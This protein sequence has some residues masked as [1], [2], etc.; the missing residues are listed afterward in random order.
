LAEI[1][2]VNEDNAT[3]TDDATPDPRDI[4]AARETLRGLISGYTA[5]QVLH[6]AAKLRLADHLAEGAL[7]AAALAGRAGADADVVQRLLNGLAAMGVV[8][9]EPGGS[10]RLTAVGEGMREDVPGSMATFALLSGE[11]YYQAWLGLDPTLPARDARTPFQRVFG[12]PV[13]DWFARHPESGER[14]Q[15]RMATRVT[16]YAPAVAAASDLA[17][18]RRIVDIGGGHGI[19]LAAFL[20]QWPG[21]RGVLF[22]LP[23]AAAAGRDQLGRMGLGER[24][25]TVG[26][27]F[28]QEGVIPA[29]GDVY[30]LSQVL[31]DWDDEKS[32][33]ILRHI[34]RAIAPDGRLL[35]IEML[36]PDR[37]TGPHPAVDLD[38]VM[39][40]LT[41]GRERTEGE[42]QRLLEAAGFT[43]AQTH[44]GVAPGGISVLEARP[45]PIV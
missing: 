17:D 15:Q 6:A 7:T 4:A 43:L 8:V 33:A 35:V 37:V 16:V 25:E 11:E 12:E 20:R 36:M 38:L 29:G 42:Y 3:M 32:L 23:D 40:V 41:G 27:D 26:G 10:F 34:R 39:L 1:G 9:A 28:F 30:L 18:A 19:L 2:S 22:D 21:A 14:F 31:H 44:E 45:A 13:F 24:V 5:T